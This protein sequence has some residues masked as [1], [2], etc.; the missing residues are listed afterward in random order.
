MAEER[1]RPSSPSSRARSFSPGSSTPL[2]GDVEP[3]VGPRVDALAEGAQQD[4]VALDRD[5]AADAEEPGRPPGYGS[6]PEP[7]RDPVVDDLEVR[8]DEALGLRDR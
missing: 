3:G 1:A 7:A 6:R 2:P 5:Q 4:D 8:L